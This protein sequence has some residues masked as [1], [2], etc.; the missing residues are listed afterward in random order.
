MAAAPRDQPAVRVVDVEA[1][2]TAVIAEETTWRLFPTRWPELLDEVWA[3]VRA[4]KLDAGRNVML[5]HDDRPRVEVGVE[6]RERFAP[7]GRVVPSSLPAG[8]AAFTIARG[9]PADALG[10][11]HDAV[12]SWSRANGHRLSGCRWEIYDHWRD[13]QDPAD[14]RTEV[15]WLLG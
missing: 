8:R 6:S 2:P 13:D 3:F 15:Y 14:Y 5:Y 10:P 12:V 4:E 9:A 1:I 11:A 7:S